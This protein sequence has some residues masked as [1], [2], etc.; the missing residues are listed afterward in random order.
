MRIYRLRYNVYC[1]EM[2]SLDPRNYPEKEERDRYD[3]FAVHFILRKN[4]KVIGTL[5]LIRETP[6]G[7]LMEEAFTLP[8]ELDRSK[9]LEASRIAVY[10]DLRGGHL[11]NFLCDAG[12]CWSLER[13][14][15][16]WCLASQVGLIQFLEESG[17]NIEKLG[18]PTDYHATTVIPL[19]RYL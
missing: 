8:K 5:R 13:G 1:E 15:S 4:Q 12:L 7:F 3:P 11:I 9:T 17:W 16:I 10:K 6:W 2:H 19:L 18:P 14:Y